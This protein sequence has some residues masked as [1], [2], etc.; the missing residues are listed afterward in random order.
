MRTVTL[1]PATPGFAFRPVG[2]KLFP[3]E[4]AVSTASPP[5]HLLGLKMGP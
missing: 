3:F 5:H 4:L 1:A 2:D